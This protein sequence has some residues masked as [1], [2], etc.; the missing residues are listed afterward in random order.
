[1]SD[2][3]AGDDTLPEG[4]KKLVHHEASIILLM[5]PQGNVFNNRAEAFK[6]MVEHPEVYSKSD[7]AEMDAKLVYEEWIT[8]ALLP[9]GWRI[10][11]LQGDVLT[12]TETGIL[13]KVVKSARAKIRLK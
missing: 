6:Y 5:S 4:W 9:T 11:K 12:L 10:K 8:N 2:W 3:D 7:I 13:Y 1:M